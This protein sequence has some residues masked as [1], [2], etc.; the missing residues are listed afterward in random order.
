M[1]PWDW[2]FSV[3]I[4]RQNH[5]WADRGMT[6]H[7]ALAI[8]HA[9]RARRWYNI[10]WPHPLNCT[11]KLTILKHLAPARR[12]HLK[13][14][15]TMGVC[16]VLSQWCL[17]LLLTTVGGQAEQHNLTFMLMTSFGQYGFNS[18]GLIPAVDMA[19][20]NI[21]SNP[22]VLPG[23]SLMYDT[24]RDSQVSLGWRLKT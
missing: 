2:Q 4:L 6:V 16:S 5:R 3:K 12:K 14:R 1:N 15:A 17:L 23:Y 22:Q 10:S 21:N 24:L 8:A 9:R 19:L 20:E 7:A 18:S 13:L 11:F